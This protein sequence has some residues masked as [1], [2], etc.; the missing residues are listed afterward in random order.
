MPSNNHNNDIK[1]LTVKQDRVLIRPRW[2][3]K[4]FV[5]AHV[6]AP[7][8][9]SNTERPRVNLGFVIDR[10]GSM[11]NGRLTLALQAVEEAI[12][13]LKPQDR[14]SVVVYDNAIDTIAPG[15]MGTPAAKDSAVEHL[16]TVGPRGSTNLGGGWL[17]GCEHVASE[18]MADGV[19]RVLL[20]T[21]GLA[22]QGMT[23]PDELATHAGELRKRGVSTSTFGVGDSFNEVLLG[24]MSQA[25]GGQFYDIATAEQ[26][27]D[28][29]ESEVGETLEVVAR[30][31][32]LDIMF[33]DE[34]RVE[35]LGAF[36][37]RS[38]GG[39][40]MIDLGDL[41]SGQELDVPLRLSFPFGEIGASTPAMFDL[42]DRD[43]VF[44]GETD[45]LAW[46]YAGDRANDEQRRDREVD[47]VIAGIYAARARRDAVDLN[48]RGEF[49][50]AGAA[51]KS[52]AKK[53]R[54]YAGG[55]P[56]LR[57]IV[58]GLMREADHFEHAMPERTRKEHYAMSSHHMR[59]RDYDG[60][61]RKRAGV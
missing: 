42:T 34:V 44:A 36:G 48:R 2:H 5:V 55:D 4:R 22:N 13:R 32:T 53:I 7:E 40:T 60:R 16:R 59:S 54:A 38:G 43:G 21:D 23:D 31:V 14:F 29:I 28:H 30:N 57:V 3:S 10:S 12:R 8:A 25:G 17:K 37:A 27:R 46:E 1:R 9:A 11:A 19:N 20:L 26:I 61:A 49:Q 47:R 56:E 50:R 41:V 6:T 51:L 35:S 52:T 45:R 18:L 24:G 58:D 15:T 39:R 33:P